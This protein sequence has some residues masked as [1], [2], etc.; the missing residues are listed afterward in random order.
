MLQRQLSHLNGLSLSA[1]KLKPLIFFVSGFALSYAANMFVHNFVWPLII[2]CT[3]LLYNR[4]HTEGWK[5]QRF[6]VYNLGT[7]HIQTTAS[8]NAVNFW[9]RICCRRN[10]FIDLLPCNGQCRHVTILFC[11][12]LLDMV[13]PPLGIPTKIL[14]IFLFAKTGLECLLHL[15]LLH[16]VIQTILGPYV[17]TNDWAQQDNKLFI[18]GWRQ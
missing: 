9:V 6:S 12:L 16:F 18:W 10:V 5:V 3:I 15:A 4:I 11:H 8:N 2:A 17:R 1:T 13:I 7:D 14:Y